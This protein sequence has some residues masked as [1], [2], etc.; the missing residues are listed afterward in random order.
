ML[1]SGSGI[2]VQRSGIKNSSLAVCKTH[3]YCMLSGGS[4]RAKRPCPHHRKKTHDRLKKSCERELQLSSWLSVSTLAVI[5]FVMYS[6]PGKIMFSAIFCRISSA[7]DRATVSLECQTGQAHWRSG[8]GRITLQKQI[9]KWAG[10]C[11]IIGISRPKYKKALGRGTAN[12]EGDT[13]PNTQPYIISWLALKLKSSAA[14]WCSGYLVGLD[15]RSC[16]TS[17]PVTTWT[18]DCWQTGKPSHFVTNHLRQLSLPLPRVDTPS[19]GMSG[20]G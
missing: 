2:L 7:F 8:P 16:S 20:W 3:Q 4:R 6:P 13:S 17:G 1:L 14:A 19:T 12:G 5:K 10:E 15:Q 9:L 18:G 11:T